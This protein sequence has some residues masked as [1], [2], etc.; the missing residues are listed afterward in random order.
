[1][2]TV[3]IGLGTNLGEREQNLAEARQLLGFA[4]DITAES[5]VIETEPWGNVDQPRFLNQVVRGETELAPERLLEELKGI[6]GLMGREPTF[7]YGPRR[8][9]LDLLY[10]DDLVLTGTKLTIPH[11]SLHLREFVLRPLVEIGPEWVHPVLGRTNFELLNELQDSGG[12]RPSDSE[13][14]PDTSK[15]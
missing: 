5:T 1:M 15:Y 14:R 12:Q 3:F 6:E 10:Y 11:A 9:D 2:A 8:I 4:L 7:R 13:D